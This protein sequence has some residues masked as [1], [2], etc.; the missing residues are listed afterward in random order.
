MRQKAFQVYTQYRNGNHPTPNTTLFDRQDHGEDELALFGGQTRILVTRLLSGSKKKRRTVA[1]PSASCSTSPSPMTESE[2]LRGSS[3]PADGSLPEVHPSLVE[4]LSTFPPSSNPT[5][6]AD[7]ACSTQ[8]SLI[9]SDNSNTWLSNSATQGT[10]SAAYTYQQGIPD[11]THTLIPGDM[12]PGQQQFTA[13]SRLENME[14]DSPE[15][16]QLLDMGMMVSGESGMDEQW[17]SFMRDS[18]IM[19]SRRASRR[20]FE[21][22]GNLNVMPMGQQDPSQ[23]T[24][25]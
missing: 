21:S 24:Y 12:T 5:S 18:G 6:N 7:T 9:P 11:S 23:V 8:V 13:P 14:T 17:I 22:F 15:N 4:Y 25:R 1:S 2:S 20:Q 19:N 10:F 3:T 16:S